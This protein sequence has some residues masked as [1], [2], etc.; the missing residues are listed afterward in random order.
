M[1]T[2]PP[3]FPCPFP[4]TTGPTIPLPLLQWPIVAPFPPLRPGCSGPDPVAP[5]WPATPTWPPKS[6]SESGVIDG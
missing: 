5:R 4:P 6:W 1:I 3:P 2:L